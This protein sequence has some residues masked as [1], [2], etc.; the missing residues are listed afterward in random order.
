MAPVHFV[1]DPLIAVL[2]TEVAAYFLMDQK[3]WT[4]VGDAFIHLGQGQ[5]IVGDVQYHTFLRH[6]HTHYVG[7][8]FRGVIAFGRC[9]R[10]LISVF[11]LLDLHVND[12]L[13]ALLNVFTQLRKHGLR[14]ASAKWSHHGWC[15]EFPF[16]TVQPSLAFL[17]IPVSF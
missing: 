12:L 17:R 9:Y 14:A 13:D 2:K 3:A 7:A 4:F 16:G 15:L 6:L 1:F 5:N 11:L 8:L 10:I